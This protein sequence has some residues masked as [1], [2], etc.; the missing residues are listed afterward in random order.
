VHCFRRISLSGFFVCACN[1]LMLASYHEE[2]IHSIVPTISH[3]EISKPNT[4]KSHSFYCTFHKMGVP[5]YAMIQI[6]KMEVL[7]SIIHPKMPM[8]PLQTH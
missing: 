3:M 4:R 5:N 1:V 2:Y 7:N 6:H 8:I